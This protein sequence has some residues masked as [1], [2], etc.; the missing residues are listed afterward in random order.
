MIF[1]ISNKKFQLDSF[2]IVQ[3]NRLRTFC[4]MTRH[5]FFDKLVFLVE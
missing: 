4:H 3:E 2:E 5:F 1:K